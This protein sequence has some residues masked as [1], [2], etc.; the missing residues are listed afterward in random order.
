MPEAEPRPEFADTTCHKIGVFIQ[1]G[2]RTERANFLR[3]IETVEIEL[4]PPLKS[5]TVVDVPLQ[6]RGIRNLVLR[7]YVR[8]GREW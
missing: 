4:P 6:E 5:G 2:G 1:I 8:I 3:V 7:V